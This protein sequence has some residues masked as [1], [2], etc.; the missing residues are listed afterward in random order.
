MKIYGVPISPFVRKTRF[1]LEL[2][3]LD[4]EIEGVFPGTQ[5]PEYLAI[6]PR[7]SLGA[8]T[9]ALYSNP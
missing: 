8:S 4:Y 7:P 3:G 9:P 5:T 6:S 2:K 1:V